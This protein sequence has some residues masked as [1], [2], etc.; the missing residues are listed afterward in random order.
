MSERLTVGTKMLK[1]QIRLLDRLQGEL[2]ERARAK[3]GPGSRVVP[4]MSKRTL[5][6]NANDLDGVANFLS[7]LRAKV[8]EEG[9]VE[10]FKGRDD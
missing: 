8:D 2:V 7:E 9:A 6:R 5:I 1:R 4:A 3:T 10:V